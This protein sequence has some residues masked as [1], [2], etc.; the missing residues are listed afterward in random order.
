[1]SSTPKEKEPREKFV[2]RYP[3][4]RRRMLRDMYDLVIL[5]NKCKY[6]RFV[7][8]PDARDHRFVNQ[9]PRGET[10]KFA[11]YYAEGTVEVARGL[12]EGRLQ[13]SKTIEHIL[14]TCTDCG[15]CEFWCENAMRV[16]PLTVMEVMKEHYVKEIGL[17]EYWKPIIENLRKTK[18][19]FGEPLEKRNTWI[20]SEAL[21]PRS[22]KI[23][24]FVGDI[25]CYKAPHIPQVAVRILHR[26]GIDVGYLYEEEWHSGYLFFRAGLYDEGLEFL[27]HNIKALEKA[28]AKT[29]IFLDPHDYRTFLKETRDANKDLPFEVKFFADYVAPLLEK[30]SSKLRKIGGKVVYHDPCN[31]TRNIMPFPVWDSPREI[32][33]IVGVEVIEMYRNRLNT[34]CCGAGGGVLFTFPELSMLTARRRLE[35]AIAVGGQSVVTMCPS[36]ISSFKNV[37][38]EFKVDVY[39]IIELIDKAF[40]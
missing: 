5:C 33:K 8:T 39:D 28:G 15:H 12:I 37:A 36:C 34:Y 21:L 29:V 27:E 31:L 19:P 35:E 3:V 22:S 14:Y 26:L 38:K 23:M 16:Y 6:C 32:L 9:C 40:T 10:F 24:L 25:Y 30:E 17:P 1:M 13:W 2:W 18:N 4:V 20:P 11:S 7:F